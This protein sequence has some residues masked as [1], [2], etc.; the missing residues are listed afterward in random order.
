MVDKKVIL[1]RGKRSRPKQ[2]YQHHKN[3]V[4]ISVY[5]PTGTTI[6]IEVRQALENSVWELAQVNKLLINI[7]Y[8]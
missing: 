3:A 4:S 6:P 5:D 2:T 7:A 8:E 1:P